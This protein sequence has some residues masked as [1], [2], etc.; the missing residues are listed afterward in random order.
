[1]GSNEINRGPHLIGDVY[2]GQ[3][4]DVEIME[5]ELQLEVRLGGI[6]VTF[7]AV[8]LFVIPNARCCV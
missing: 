7:F 8:L 6:T 5:E 1:M 3:A 2:S 4:L